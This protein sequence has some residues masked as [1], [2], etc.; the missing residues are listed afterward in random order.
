MRNEFESGAGYLAFLDVIDT[1]WCWVSGVTRR[2]AEGHLAFLRHR[3]PGRYA[4][5]AFWCQTKPEY[6]TDASVAR[7]VIVSTEA[8]PCT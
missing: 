5:H 6:V 1:R 2:R 7:P 4:G 8:D 3:H